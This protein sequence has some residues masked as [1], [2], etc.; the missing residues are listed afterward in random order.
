MRCRALICGG[1]DRSGRVGGDGGDARPLARRARGIRGLGIAHGPPAGDQFTGLRFQQ[2]RPS[3]GG[4][5]GL[6]DGRRW[7]VFDYR[8]F[9]MVC[10]GQ[11][12]RLLANRWQ[13]HRRISRVGFPS[14]CTAAHRRVLEGEK[15]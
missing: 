15:V 14:L 4:P 10:L 7:P 2:S 3:P 8:T 9:R 6:C 12:G 5:E 11:E 13:R 1:A